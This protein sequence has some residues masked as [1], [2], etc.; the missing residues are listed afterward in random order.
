MHH[1]GASA[2]EMRDLDA[3]NHLENMPTSS[4]ENECIPEENVSITED[5]STEDKL[6]NMRAIVNGTMRR[7]LYFNPAYFEPHLLQ[8]PPAAAIEF[9][10]KIR[11]VITIAKYKM[12]SKRYQPSLNLIPEENQMAEIMSQ[13]SHA[14]DSQRDSVK[15]LKRDNTRHLSCSGCPGCENNKQNDPNNCRNC[16]DKSNSIRKWLEGVSANETTTKDEIHEHTH[17]LTN[18]DKCSETSSSSDNDTIKANSIKSKRSNKGKAPPIPANPP[19]VVSTSFKTQ[20]HNEIEKVMSKSEER[21]IS[22]NKQRPNVEKIYSKSIETNESIYSRNIELYNKIARSGGNLF[23]NP[24]FDQQSPSTSRRSTYRSRKKIEVLDQYANPS[25][26]QN[27]RQYEM[28]RNIHHMP[29]M[30]YEALT[31]DYT[32]MKGNQ[33]QLPTPD[34]ITDDETKSKKSFKDENGPFVPTP[35]YNTIG[36]IPKRPNYQPD[37]PIYSR[38]SPHYLIVDYETDSLERSSNTK[39]RNASSPIK[40]GSS[41]RSQASPSLSTALPLDEEIEIR[42]AVYDRLKG[43]RK[44]PTSIEKK[45]KPSSVYELVGFNPNHIRPIETKQPKVI[46]NT[47]Y[48]GSMTIEVDHNPYDLELSTDS[49]QF[50]PDTLDR[51]PRKNNVKSKSISPPTV[52]PEKNEKMNYTSNEPLSLPDMSSMQEKKQDQLVLKSPGTFKNGVVQSQTT[53]TVVEEPKRSIGSLLEIYEAKN[54]KNLQTPKIIPDP[55]EKGRI[56]TLDARHSKRQRKRNDGSLKKLVPP[57]GTLTKLAPPDV[58]PSNNQNAYNSDDLRSLKSVIQEH[59]DNETFDKTSNTSEQNEEQKLNHMDYMSHTFFKDYSNV[60]KLS[61]FNTLRKSPE[62]KEFI[63]ESSGCFINKM[64]NNPPYGILENFMTLGD[65]RNQNFIEDNNRIYNYSDDNDSARSIS[66][67]EQHSSNSSNNSHAAGKELEDLDK[68]EELSSKSLS[69][70]SKKIDNSLTTTKVFRVEIN[71]STHGMQIAL[72]L[73]DR[74]K[75]SKDMKNAWRRFMSIATSKFN[76]N[77]TDGKSDSDFYEKSSVISDTAIEPTIIDNSTNKKLLARLSPKSE[78]ESGYIS[79]DSN[80]S[81]LQNHRYERYNFKIKGSTSS[82]NIYDVIEDMKDENQ[83][84]QNF[85]KKIV[86]GIK[87]SPTRSLEKMKPTSPPPPPPLPPTPS[88]PPPT[89]AS[90]SVTKMMENVMQPMNCIL[91]IKDAVS[92]N[93]YSSDDERYSSGLSSDEESAEGDG[94][95]SGAE[96]V[97]TH[98]VLFKNIRKN[99]N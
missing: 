91:E 58:V 18:H 66:P 26:I 50:E 57:E 3:M 78:L 4:Q 79:S 99:N 39:R 42:N 37:S 43:F 32:K 20:P 84:E 24:Q 13:S 38:K 74:A 17:K 52:P 72:G 29:D 53:G 1:Q 55:M 65:I 14:V 5:M 59:E 70:D 28:M 63:T 67:N 61:K 51:K 45:S 30:V 49:D 93:L 11:E 47:P 69:L 75:K 81:R 83:E 16:G 98:S 46:Y 34:Y 76:N 86:E 27:H 31:M 35:D 54:F 80:E 90:S 94:C 22:N 23:N 41:D 73:K 96:S 10:T 25:E 56:L 88:P 12:S 92:V 21:E 7:K 36:R 87:T 82:S 97:E 71:Q 85:D 33:Y 19:K 95:E 89:P 8:A 2:N 60:D 15:S 64:E 48:Q 40:S 6:E 77:K 62:A 68:I 44:D 9:L